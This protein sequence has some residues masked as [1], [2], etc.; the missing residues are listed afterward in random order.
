MRYDGF[1]LRQNLK[2]VP[3]AQYSSHRIYTP[4]IFAHTPPN[5]RIGKL[6]QNIY[7]NLGRLARKHKPFCPSW[8]FKHTGLSKLVA[9]TTILRHFFQSWIREIRQIVRNQCQLGQLTVIADFFCDTPSAPHTK[10]SNCLLF[11]HEAA[12]SCSACSTS[13][14]QRDSLQREK[15]SQNEPIKFMRRYQ[16]PK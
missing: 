15:P 11:M 9:R 8:D 16:L 5:R 13:S 4:A 7:R 14:L 2:K 6:A 1:S 3:H 12:I 10:S